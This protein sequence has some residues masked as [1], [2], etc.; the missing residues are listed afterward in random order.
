MTEVEEKTEFKFSELDDAAKDKARAA[1]TADGYLDHNWWDTTY[2]GAVR[3]ASILGIEI[4]STRHMGSNGKTYQTTDI[5]FSGFC[6]QGDGA[7]FKGNYRIAP[8]AS[9]L[10]RQETNDEVLHALADRLSLMQL[11]RKLQ[12]LTPSTANISTSGRYSHSGAM[13]VTVSYDEDED[14]ETSYD[15]ALDKGVT[16]VMRDFAD[17]IYAQLE[18]GYDWLHSNEC[19]DE[20]LGEEKFDESGDVI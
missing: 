1:H 11:T 14:G 13:D 10:I 15:D 16:Q 19:V 20:A 18:T 12:G 3:L 8:E 17:W 9:A 2:T 4:S 7:C 5:A 6:S